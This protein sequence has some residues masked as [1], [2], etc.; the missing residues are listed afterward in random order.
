MHDAWPELPYTEW[1]DTKDTL[2]M[3]AQ[4]VG[5]TALSHSP[6][7][8]HWWNCGLEVTERGLSTPLLYEDD[9]PFRIELD[10][11]EHELH[12]Y[13]KQQQPRSFRLGDSVADFYEIFKKA[14]HY[15]VL[16]PRIWPVPVE[17][18]NGIPFKED[19]QHASYNPGS[20][21]RFH[22]LLLSVQRVL[23]QFRASYCGKCSPVL[24]WWG[25]FDIC[26]TRFSG[27]PAPPREGADRILREAMSHEEISCGWWPGDDATPEAYFYAYAAP[28]PDG[29]GTQRLLPSEAFYSAEKQEFFLPYEAVRTAM[30]PDAA[31][32]DFF[33]STYEAGA[34][35]GKWD[36]GLV[37][38]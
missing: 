13:A 14:M 28:E 17:I 26:V 22:Q 7:I 18:S 20:V 19:T 3:Y 35:L 8:N 32:L 16:H 21:E 27:R 31:A 10:F 38:S 5:K 36:I 12:I 25:T 4:I 34:G 30:D 15:S 9:V 37:R 2:H 1:K 11:I 23:N 6:R 33:Q 29:I 24:F